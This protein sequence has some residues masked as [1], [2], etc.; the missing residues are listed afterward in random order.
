MSRTGYIYEIKCMDTSIKDIYIGSTWSIPTRK[1]AHKS[2][3]TNPNSHLYNN[4]LYTFIRKNSG[5][6]N[7]DMVVIDCEECDGLMERKE[8]EQYYIDIY[9]G[10][11]FLLNEMDAIVNPEKNK[12]Y[13]ARWAK[14]NSVRVKK[15][16]NAPIVTGKQWHPFH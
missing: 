11:D 9:G 12:E 16:K 2:T 4:E 5:W 7:F 1:S 13:K 3:S 8:L 14:E 15:T 6:E 10:I